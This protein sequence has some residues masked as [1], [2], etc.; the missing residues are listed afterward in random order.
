MT[1][2]TAAVNAL[3]A[4]LVSIGKSLGPFTQVITHEPKSAPTSLPAAA[5]WFRRL[6]PAGAASGLA[7]VSGVV[8]FTWRVYQASMLAEPQ[9]AID[10]GLLKN[11]ALVLEALSENFTLTGN[12]RN[13]DL[14]GELGQQLEAVSGFIAH[15]GKLL[16]VADITIPCIVNDLWQEV[17]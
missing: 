13:V 9:N 16:R 1:F 2:N 11:T 17:P 6:A 12:A 4:E 5:I 7:S 10:P 14:F 8:T 3:F 15:D